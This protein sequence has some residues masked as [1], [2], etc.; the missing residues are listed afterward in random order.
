MYKLLFI[1]LAFLTLCDQ[2]LKSAIIVFDRNFLWKEERQNFVLVDN[3]LTLATCN[4]RR[5]NGKRKISF[6]FIFNKTKSA[7]LNYFAPQKWPI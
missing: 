5:F 6:N 7:E 1:Q 2:A 4:T 3:C